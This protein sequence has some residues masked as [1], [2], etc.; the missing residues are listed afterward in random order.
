MEKIAANA[1]IDSIYNATE[2]VVDKYL[3]DTALVAIC[4]STTGFFAAI[5]TPLIKVI[6]ENTAFKLARMI[7][8]E[9]QMQIDIIEGKITLKKVDDAKISNDELAYRDAVGRY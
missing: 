2:D 6:F 3:I 7:K 4:G 9:G 1:I 8:R 5:L